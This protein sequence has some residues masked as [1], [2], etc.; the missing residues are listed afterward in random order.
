MLSEGAAEAPKVKS[1]ISI[2]DNW[3]KPTTMGSTNSA[4]EDEVIS[5]STIKWKISCTL[6]ENGRAMKKE[7]AAVAHDLVSEYE[8]GP[9][10]EENAMSNDFLEFKI[11]MFAEM[12]SVKTLVTNLSIPTARDNSTTPSKDYESFFIKTLQDRIISLER[13]LMQK[14]K[15]LL[16]SY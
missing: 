7:V 15:I 3:D 9:G 12:S 1:D 10:S 16:T 6:S 8:K 5:E 11:Y 4:K 14:K 2:L 13:Q